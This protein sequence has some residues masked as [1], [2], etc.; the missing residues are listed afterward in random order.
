[1]NSSKRRAQVPASTI[2]S[3]TTTFSRERSD[4]RPVGLGRVAAIG[5]TVGHHDLALFHRSRPPEYLI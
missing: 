3:G 1:M 2:S 5:L 4:A